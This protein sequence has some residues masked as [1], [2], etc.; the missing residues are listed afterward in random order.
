MVTEK[1]GVRGRSAGK[2]P[3]SVLHILSSAN[4]NKKMKNQHR[5]PALEEAGWDRLATL[6]VWTPIRGSG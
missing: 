3:G 5:S 2:K 1:V 4:L 6:R